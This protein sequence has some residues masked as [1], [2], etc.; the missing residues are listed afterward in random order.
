MVPFS[1]DEPAGCVMRLRLCF[2]LMTLFVL[3]T[4]EAQPSEPTPNNTPAAEDVA[5]REAVFQIPTQSLATALIEFSDQA[6]LQVISSGDEVAK[7]IASEV[8][9]RRRI[10]DAIEIMLK[11]TGLRYTVVS[12]DIISIHPKLSSRSVDAAASVEA[13]P[14]D[15]WYWSDDDE[16]LEAI[17]VT[18]TRIIRDG[19]EAPTPTTVVSNETLKVLAAS[20]VADAVNFVPALAGS[21][22]PRS[23]NSG[24]S[25][26]QAGTNTL[27]LRSM[28][29]N[30]TL[31]LMDGARLT[32][33]ALTG[34]V[35]I[36][37]LPDGL[38]ERVDVV[39]GG[40]SAAYGSDAMTGVVNFVLAKDFAGLTTATL[41]GII[42]N[43]V[44]AALR[45]AGVAELHQKLSVPGELGVP[46]R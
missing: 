25:G 16:V 42:T 4:A 33:T 3:A 23:G 45:R 29:A 35:D 37:Q 19:Y 39:T 20:N 46:A 15:R 34:V 10:I 5:S 7:S 2:A 30:R 22:T 11:G 17:I 8:R 27:D 24:V 6:H 44:R 28:G 13:K 26:G 31:V 32:P 12:Q 18:A 14:D 40:A 36:N 1:A 9:G 21:A 38:I 41:G 43:T